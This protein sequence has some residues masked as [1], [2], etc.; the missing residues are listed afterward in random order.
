MVHFPCPQCG[1]RLDVDPGFRGAVARCE[2]C[3]ALITVPSKSEG[4]HPPRERPTAPGAPGSL[5]PPGTAASSR[6]GNPGAPTAR[7]P[8]PRRSSLVVIL[9]VIALILGA[10]AVAWV[11]A[12]RS[13]GLR[14]PSNATPPP[15][16][17]PA[18]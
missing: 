4:V 12:S 2:H 7:A 13:K 9:A 11:W 3:G 6:S 17:A 5:S 1:K 18:H 10:A 8:R 14:T 15:A 16:S